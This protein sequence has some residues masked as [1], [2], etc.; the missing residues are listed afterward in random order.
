[1]PVLQI[2]RSALLLVSTFFNFMA[3][4]YLQLD[5]NMSI[6]FSTPFFVAILSGPLLGERVDWRRW[7]AIGAGFLGVVL[8]GGPGAGGIHPAALFSV[9]GAVCY[10][11]YAIA[12][13]LLARTD[14]NATTLFYS[15]LIGAFAMLP[16]L[17]FIWTAP[18]SPFIVLLMVAMG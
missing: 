3:L 8:V 4:R 12:T 15:N 14:S 1:R 5:Q 7:I 10:A 9:G 11:F 17:P 2:G 16:V 13:R 6:A 18:G